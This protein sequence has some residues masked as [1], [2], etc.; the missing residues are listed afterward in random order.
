[1]TA[2]LLD[3][4]VVID[5]DDPAVA[6]ALPGEAAVSAITLAG[7]AA[8]PHLASPV[9]EGARR[10][11]RLQKVEAT[12][13]PSPSMSRQH[14]ATDRSWRLSPI[15]VAHTGA[16]SRTCSSR[17]PPTPTGSRSTPVTPATSPVSATSSRSLLCHTAR[18]VEESGHARARSDAARAAVAAWRS[19]ARSTSAPESPARTSRPSPP[20]STST[21]RAPT[22]T[23][24]SAGS[25]RPSNVSVCS[26]PVVAA[27][28]CRRFE[29]GS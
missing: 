19:R 1:M 5:W 21:R 3:I 2:G 8:G 16:A 27:R 10:Q 28:F 14:A 18:G 9:A 26:L 17:Q 7:L 6:A 29:R 13:H 25:P 4:S 20:N 12:S 23:S 11:A 22:A 15:L 24:R